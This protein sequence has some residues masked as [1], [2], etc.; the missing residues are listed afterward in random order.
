MTITTSYTFTHNAMESGV[1][2][3][4]TDVVDENMEYLK[5]VQDQKEDI[6]QSV[7]TLATSGSLT[8]QDNK[9]HKVAPTSNITFVL[10]TITDTTSFHQIVVQVTKASNVTIGLGTTDYFGRIQ[11]DVSGVGRF[12]IYYE[13]DGTSWVC[14]ALAKGSET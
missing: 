2:T 11:P 4:D 10:P 3:C 12:N 6:A 9:I 5:D 13:W 7:V 14:G 8:L 1:A